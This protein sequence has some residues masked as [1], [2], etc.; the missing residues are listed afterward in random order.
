MIFNYLFN[1]VPFFFHLLWDLFFPIFIYTNMNLCT[2]AK[3]LFSFYKRSLLR[4][5]YITNEFSYVWV[6]HIF[7]IFCFQM[8][9][10]RSSQPLCGQQGRR[11]KEDETYLST[12]TQRLKKKGFVLDTRTSSA[13]NSH[14]SKG[15]E[16][17]LEFSKDI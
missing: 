3:L 11:C 10:L 6:I 14:K 16:S 7:E 13:I 9:L 5:G 8:P 2:R 15:K 1:F 4:K 12:L 17:H